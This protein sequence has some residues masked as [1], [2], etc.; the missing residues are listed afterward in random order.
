M[1]IRMGYWD[2]QSCGTQHIEGPKRDC[3]QCGRPR[4]KNVAFYTDDSAPEVTDSAL[5]ERAHAGADWHCPYCDCD[6]KAGATVCVSCGATLG[7]RQGTAREIKVQYDQLPVATKA[8]AKRSI[9]KGVLLAIAAGVLALGVSAWFLFLRTSP[10]D[11]TVTSHSWTKALVIERLETQRNAAWRDEVPG[12]AREVGRETRSRDKKVQEGTERVKVGKKDLGNG[13]F[14][15]VYEERP[16]YVTKTFQDTWVSYEV[17]RWVQGQT[18]KNEGQ[19][20]NEPAYPTYTPGYKERIGRREN[21][22]ALGLRDAKNKEYSFKIEIN[23]DETKR[24]R[25][26]SFA[27]GQRYTALITAV[28]HVSEL[29]TAQ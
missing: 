6:N 10:H 16:R 20:G 22:V 18:I 25:A 5:L 12:G 28:G 14:E 1:A 9:G 26:R 19:A 17:D 7:D 21:H 4:D 27:I 13:L 24:Q 15:D 3:P 8:A 11:V 29:Q 23:D 2:C